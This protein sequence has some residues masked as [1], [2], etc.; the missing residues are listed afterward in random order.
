MPSAHTHTISCRKIFSQ[1]CSTFFPLAKKKE[2]T[3]SWPWRATT[4]LQ[5]IDF[6]PFSAGLTLF[7]KRYMQCC[8]KTNLRPFLLL[9][10]GKCRNLL[11]FSS[12]WEKIGFSKLFCSIYWQ[13]G[14]TWTWGLTAATLVLFGYKTYRKLTCCWARTSKPHSSSMC[15]IWSTNKTPTCSIHL[16]CQIALQSCRFLCSARITPILRRSAQWWVSA[17]FFPRRIPWIS[18]RLTFCSF[19]WRLARRFQ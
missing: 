7:R 10:L 11:G 13:W 8:L 3:W 12:N 19:T 9:S 5:P 15:S 16:H 6:L 14:I 18:Q 1:A 17:S 4:G 2:N